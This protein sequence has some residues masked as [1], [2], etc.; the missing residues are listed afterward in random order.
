MIRRRDGWAGMLGG[1]GWWRTFGGLL[2]FELL[3]LRHSRGFWVWVVILGLLGLV[4]AQTGGAG[5]AVANTPALV[6]S[7]AI[8]LLCVNDLDAGALKN[9]L[10]GRHGRGAYVVAMMALVAGLTVVLSAL[11]WLIMA[12]RSWVGWQF[13]GVLL[14]PQ[15]PSVW[16]GAVLICTL[17]SVAPTLFVAILT[18]SQPLATIVAL[19]GVGSIPVIVLANGAQGAGLDGLSNLIWELSPLEAMTALASG[20]VPEA[21]ALVVAL[22]TIALF[23][24]L[25]LWAMGRRDVS[26]CAE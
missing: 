14:V 26:I 4:G 17:A 16:M 5:C 11:W 7:V 13:E 21:L 2:R 12:V 19:L 25:S 3:R 10:V 20:A 9:V 24:V 8:P 1:F 22:A 23:T 18:R 6:M 15:N